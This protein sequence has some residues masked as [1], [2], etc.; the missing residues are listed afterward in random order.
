MPLSLLELM[1]TDN[2]S[3]TDMLTAK[4]FD[5]FPRHVVTKDEKEEW[6]EASKAA[7]EKASLVWLEKI[8]RMFGSVLNGG[9]DD[10]DDGDD[11]GGIMGEDDD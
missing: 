5:A 8:I 4:H 11:D 9:E 10:G 7:A 2:Q 1:S 6:T 3:P